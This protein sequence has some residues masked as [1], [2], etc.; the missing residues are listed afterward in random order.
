M[1]GTEFEFIITNKKGWIYT[2]KT[3]CLIHENTQSHGETSTEGLKNAG[4]TLIGNHTA[5]V[6]GAAYNFY[7]PGEI[8]LAFTISYVPG[9]GKGIQ[10]DILVT[11]TIKGIQ[12]GR[13]EILERAVKF[14]EKGK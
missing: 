1:P 11:P 14:L 9:E 4:A 8:R 12:Q 7:I 6:N 2:G 3:V 5:G 13:D 10:P